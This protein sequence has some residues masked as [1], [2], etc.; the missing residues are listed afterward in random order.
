MTVHCNVG[1]DVNV[2]IDVNLLY[3]LNIHESYVKYSV[4][5]LVNFA[6][7]I[8]KLVGAFSPVNYT[9]LHQG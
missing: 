7:K 9:G 3:Q 5:I 6:F 4:V 2:S 8:S 1:V